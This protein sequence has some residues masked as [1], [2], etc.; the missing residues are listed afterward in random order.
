MRFSWSA[1]FVGPGTSVVGSSKI[2]MGRCTYATIVAY[3]PPELAISFSIAAG[4]VRYAVRS[5]P[6]S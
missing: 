6:G 1:L 5:T 2:V 4:T 3:V